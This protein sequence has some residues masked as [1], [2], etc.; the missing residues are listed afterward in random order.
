M[1]GWE[2]ETANSAFKT[3]APLID[4]ATGAPV[5]SVEL[6]GRS[7]QGYLLASPERIYVPTGRAQPFALARSDGSELGSYGAPGGSY[8]VLLEEGLASGPG[9]TGQLQVF[10]PES[11]ER[12]AS[13]EAG[14][15]A[16]RGGR[17]WLLSSSLVQALDRGER[18]RLLAERATRIPS[19]S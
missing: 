2:A 19:R 16:V 11:A 7:P 3:G 4:A 9:N 18:A 5:W 12:L 10:A 8:A 1:V 13:Y 14:R 15:M 6:D 17:S